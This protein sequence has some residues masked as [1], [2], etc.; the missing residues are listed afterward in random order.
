VP[1]FG[2]RTAAF[3]QATA[4]YSNMRLPASQEKSLTISW[5][6]QEP[7]FQAGHPADATNPADFFH[8]LLQRITKFEIRQAFLRKPY[9]LFP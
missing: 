7:I 3:L 5:F 9:I 1:C 8:D 6:S 2:G 4:D